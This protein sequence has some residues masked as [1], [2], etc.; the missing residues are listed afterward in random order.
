[1]SAVDWLLLLVLSVLWGGSFFVMAVALRELPPLTIVTLRV[2]IGA[3]LLNIAIIARGERLPSDARILR[4]FAVMGALNN[5]VP[6]TLLGLALGQI[7]SG[8]AAILNATT[9]FFTVVVAHLWTADEKITA[10]RGLGLVVGFLGV[11][12]M[13]SRGLTSG[14]GASLA[15]QLACLAAALC[16]AL[17]GVY[18]RRFKQFGMT[19]MQTA[20]GQVS[21]STL[22]IAPIAAFIDQPWQLQAPS[23]TATI[24][25]VAAGSLSTALGYVLYFRILSSSGANNVLL[26][27]FLI[28]VSAI[29]LGTIGLHEQL[30]TEHIAGM[31]LIGAGLVVIDGRLTRTLRDLRRAQTLS[32]G[33]APR[34]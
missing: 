29:L 22:L 19:P 10:R 6:F 23:L 1:M 17:A 27:T 26:V 3:L 24:A 32:S 9:P 14:T 15:A 20:A 30:G 21:A 25:I 11:V 18:G 2:G 16:Y 33:P 28:P 4:S 34:Q 5:V 7:P 12:V 8:L 13:F 31:L